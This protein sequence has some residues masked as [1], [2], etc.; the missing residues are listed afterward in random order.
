MTATLLF[1]CYWHVIKFIHSFILNCG[2]LSPSSIPE[3]EAAMHRP[4]CSSLHGASCVPLCV[5]LCFRTPPRGTVPQRVHPGE[6]LGRSQPGTVMKKA[7]AGRVRV[8]PRLHFSW[9]N[10]QQQIGWVT[11]RA[12]AAQLS[13]TLLGCFPK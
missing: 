3:V 9:A 10:A 6:T 1:S 7:A 2:A 5:S 11:C 13:G 12:F 8:D 4:G